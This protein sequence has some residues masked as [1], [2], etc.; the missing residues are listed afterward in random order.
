MTLAAMKL[1]QRDGV[2]CGPAVAVLAGALLDPAYRTRLP[3]VGWFHAEQG[4]IHRGVNWL[5]PR[6]LG[7]T[8]MGVANAISVH[9]ARYGV[10]YRW[11]PCSGLLGRRDRLV[12]V[13]RAVE[14]GWPVAMLVGRVVPRHWVLLVELSGEVLTCYEPSSGALRSVGT[15]AVRGARLS[16]LGFPRPFAFVLPGSSSA[17]RIETSGA[18]SASPATTP[19]RF[20][21][22]WF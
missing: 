14:A 6:R 15:D 19:E 20:R 16:G 4:R 22:V 12:D 11:R 21:A 18:E 2:T 10:R 7:T 5:W 3:A 17:T 13:L 1:R 8:P 9:G